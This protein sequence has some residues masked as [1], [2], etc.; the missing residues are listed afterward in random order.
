M[1]HWEKRGSGPRTRAQAQRQEPSGLAGVAARAASTGAETRLAPPLP[2]SRAASSGGRAARSLSGPPPN[3]R[4]RLQLCQLRASP[5]QPR[6]RAGARGPPGLQVGARGAPG[7]PAF[8]WRRP[9]SLLPPAPGPELGRDLGSGRGG[10][11]GPASRSA[12]GGLAR[13]PP[14]PVPAGRTP[15]AWARTFAGAGAAGARSRAG[16]RRGWGCPPPRPPPSPCSG[17]SRAPGFARWVVTGVAGA[18][19][20]AAPRG[21]EPSLPDTR[22]RAR[23]HTAARRGARR[24]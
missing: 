7:E 17:S 11:A 1:K 24:W 14:S 10:L 9:L 19:G 22:P 13:A 16:C 12:L 4:P 18:T 15:A 5:P 2:A 6:R 23:G 21:S 3:L 20:R 8:R